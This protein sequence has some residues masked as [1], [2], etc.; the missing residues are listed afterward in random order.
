LTGPDGNNWDLAVLKNFQLP[1]VPGSTPV[2]NFVGRPSI[3]LTIRS[4]KEQI[5]AVTA[6]LTPTAIQR[7]AAL[8]GYG[9]SWV[10]D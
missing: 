4:G 8:G 1:L 10:N 3:R 2:G 5:S 6:T 7:L 9:H